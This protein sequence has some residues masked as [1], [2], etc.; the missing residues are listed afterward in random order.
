M[1]NKGQ[2]SE[3][4]ANTDAVDE[5]SGYSEDN[6]FVVDT[7]T[8]ESRDQAGA[9]DEDEEVDAEVTGN[10]N[11]SINASLDELKDADVLKGMITRLRHENGNHRKRNKELVSEN[12]TL[13]AEKAKRMN[14]VKEAKER[15]ERAE[16]RAKAYVIKLAAEE[17]GIDED[18]ID[19]VDGAT[20]EEIY[21]RAELL[22]E[23]L[24]ATNKRK[25]DY[26]LPSSFDPFAGR[27]GRPVR[28]QGQKDP[29]GEYLRDLLS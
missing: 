20:D 7:V 19:L 25:P 29:G 18:L 24:M 9:A 14:S 8:P 27:R 17:Y 4:N 1:S 22:A 6:P 2:V 3:D 23:R 26:E 16:A 11:D 21:A 5:V 13:K 12:E 28:G 15:A 10:T